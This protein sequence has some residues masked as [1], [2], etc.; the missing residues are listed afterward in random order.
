MQELLIKNDVIHGK[1]TIFDWNC[2]NYDKTWTFVVRNKI[3]T[4]YSSHKKCY[5]NTVGESEYDYYKYVSVMIDSDGKMVFEEFCNNQSELNSEQ[6]KV[7]HCYEK[8]V[9]DERRIQNHVD[10]L[11]YSTIENVHTIVRTTM[12]TMPDINAIWNGLEE[13]D[14]N[15]KLSIEQL[16]D[17][18]SAF[19]TFVP[20]YSEYAFYL[21]SELTKF[22]NVITKNEFRKIINYRKYRNAAKSWYDFLYSNY[23]IRII[24]EIKAKKF[25]AV[26]LIDNVLDIK[27]Y[28]EISH[29]GKKELRYFVGTKHNDL[30]TSVHNACIVRKV[31]ADNENIEFEELLPLMAV[32]FVRNKQHTVL[33][34]PYKY[35][36]E[37]LALKKA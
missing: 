5:T 11:V 33:P 29:L 23:G 36:R 15:T 7:I 32:E 14:K 8:A 10:G 28:T 30:K 24:A 1:V 4:G 31:I 26:Y 9:S 21:K 3:N 12:T 13:T 16:N 34:F 19:I 27:Y 2:L 37:Y 25:N 22:Q 18:L 17:A 6:E 35:L 20:E